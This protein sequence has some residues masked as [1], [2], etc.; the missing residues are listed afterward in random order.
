MLKLLQRDPNDRFQSAAEVKLALVDLTDSLG[1]ARPRVNSVPVEEPLLDI[2]RAA[3]SAQSE[4]DIIELRVQVPEHGEQQ[5]AH[6]EES[7]SETFPHLRTP[8]SLRHGVK[9]NLVRCLVTGI[10]GLAVVWLGLFEL[11]LNGTLDQWLNQ[12]QLDRS[13][14]IL[15]VAS[16]ISKSEPL[17][18]DVEHKSLTEVVTSDSHVVSHAVEEVAEKATV[19]D[20]PNAELPVIPV[21]SKEL[22]KIKTKK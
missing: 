16:P 13:I 11:H 9:M 1:L 4:A 8:W 12:Y 14:Q 3:E 21:L 18:K 2:V 17:G 22:S 10:L 15:P 5:G 7:D 19:M 6:V 20:N